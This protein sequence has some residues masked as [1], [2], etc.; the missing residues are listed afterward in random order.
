MLDKST[1]RKVAEKYAEKVKK[2][3]KPNAIV[4]FG[5]HVNGNSHAH[6]DIDIAIICNDFEGNWHDVMV[7]LLGIAWE[8]DDFDDFVIE[9]HLLNE[10]KDVTGF[11]KHVINTGEYIYKAA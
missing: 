9:P 4:L 3:L 8:H 1:V 6:S 2:I 5:S 10:N 11:V 7:A